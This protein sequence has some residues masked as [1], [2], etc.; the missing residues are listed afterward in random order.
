LK[1]QPEHARALK[2]GPSP[3][4]PSVDAGAITQFELKN[5]LPT[6]NWFIR[7]GSMPGAVRA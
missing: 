2:T 6:K 7:E 3:S 1:W 4:R 5:E